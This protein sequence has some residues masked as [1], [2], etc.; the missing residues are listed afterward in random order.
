[1]DCEHL[2]GTMLNV[3]AGLIPPSPQ[4]ERH[5]QTCLKCSK[6]FDNLCTTMQLLDEWSVSDP[7]PHF[8]AVLR[9]NLLEMK[10]TPPRN[11]WSWFS[12]SAAAVSFAGLLFVGAVIVEHSLLRKDSA[13]SKPELTAP[14]GTAVGDLQALE[15]NGDLYDSDLLD[16]LAVD[17][18]SSAN[19]N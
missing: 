4:L 7:S 16:E 2:L 1:V 11:W 12:F 9:T 18:P 14:Q 6:Q 5:L 13:R 8:D 10:P 3:A 17:Q 19:S 15:D